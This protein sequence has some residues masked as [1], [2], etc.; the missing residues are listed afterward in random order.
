[1]RERERERD[2]GGGRGWRGEPDRQTDEHTHKQSKR[3][4][5]VGGT[6]TNRYTNKPPDRRRQ[7]DNRKR[8]PVNRNPASYTDYIIQTDSR[9][10]ITVRQAGN[11]F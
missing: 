6:E 7:R 11:W 1:M 3:E 9:F 2:T 8:D 10:F 4:R 5:G